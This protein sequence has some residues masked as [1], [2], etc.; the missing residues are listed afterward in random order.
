MSRIEIVDPRKHVWRGGG[1]RRHVVS[2]GLRWDGTGF[3][4]CSEPECEINRE[5]SR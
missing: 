5:P 2:W 3:R 4:K 1:W